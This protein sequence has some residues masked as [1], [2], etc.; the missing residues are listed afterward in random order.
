MIRAIMHGCNGK[1]GQVITGLVKNDPE[2]EFVAGI[3]AYT[4]MNLESGDIIEVGEKSTMTLSL[5]SNKYLSL[6]PNTVLELIAEGTEEDSKTTVNLKSGGV[7]NE[8]TEPLSDESSY[9]VNTPKATMAVRGTSFYVS[10]MAVDDGSY[11]TDISVFHG[12][13]EI[14]LIDEEGNPRGDPVIVQPNETVAILTV[15]SEGNISGAEINGTSS[16]IIRKSDGSNTFYLVEDGESPIMPLNLN[17]IP[18]RLNF[19]R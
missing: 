9:S 18:A 6:D 12:K 2:I 19:F 15:P 5:D 16:F 1:M 13:V 7:L 8:I 11:I 17:I 14:Q 3:D 4:G 10:V